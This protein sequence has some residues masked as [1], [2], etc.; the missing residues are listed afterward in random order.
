ME[1]LFRQCNLFLG[2]LGFLGRL[3]SLGLLGSRSLGASSLA[4]LFRLCG[5]LLCL[6]SL[7]LLLGLISLL[8]LGSCLFGLLLVCL[9]LA[10]RLLLGLGCCLWGC[11]LG[12]LVPIRLGFAGRL[13]LGFAGW[14]LFGFGCFLGRLL[15][16]FLLHRNW[17]TISIVRFYSLLQADGAEQQIHTS[18]LPSAFSSVGSSA[19]FL[20]EEVALVSSFLSASY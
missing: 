15:L 19:F 13:L 7:G 8:G 5:V 20:L 3:L 10:G 16:Y 18:D 1:R 4:C 12:R 17:D 2:C 9:C 11:L 6:C 14:L